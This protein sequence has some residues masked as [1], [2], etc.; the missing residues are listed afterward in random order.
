MALFNIEKHGI[1]IFIEFQSDFLLFV[2]NTWIGRKTC[3]QSWQVHYYYLHLFGV[4]VIGFTEHLVI[5][6]AYLFSVKQD[7]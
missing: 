2:S 5:D 3:W 6:V 4:W 1:V 7:S